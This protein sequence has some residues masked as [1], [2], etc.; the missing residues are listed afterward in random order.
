MAECEVGASTDRWLRW[1][2][3]NEPQEALTAGRHVVFGED[4]AGAPLV[5]DSHTD[6][7]SAYWFKGGEWETLAAS[8]HA[9]FEALF[10]PDSK[11][12]PEWALAIAQIQNAPAASA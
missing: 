10:N 1:L 2:Q 8:P 9:F 11:E 4:S 7:I 6:Q 5:W 12:N 3:E